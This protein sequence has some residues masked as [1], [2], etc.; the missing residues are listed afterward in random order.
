VAAI[1]GCSVGPSA[2]LPEAW[3]TALSVL[4]PEGLKFLPPIVDILM[5]PANTHASPVYKG[6]NFDTLLAPR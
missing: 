1:C 2:A 5:I 6:P 3:S 4:G